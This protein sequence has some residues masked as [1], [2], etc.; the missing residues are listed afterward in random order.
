MKGL[1]FVLLVITSTM[2]FAQQLDRPEPAY[3]KNPVLPALEILQ[4]DSTTLT[5]ANLKKQETMIMYFSPDCEH[6]IRQM[7]DMIKRMKD[8]KK[9]QIIMVTYQPM[10]LLVDFI[11]TYK[12][13]KYSNIKTGRDTKFLLPGFYQIKSLPY[14]ALY[15]KEGKLITTFESNTKVDTLLKAFEKK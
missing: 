8:L 12:L 15:D 14:F 2:G 4:P 10:D 11:K 3:K 6:C 7:N 9:L 13:Q 5:N 1:L